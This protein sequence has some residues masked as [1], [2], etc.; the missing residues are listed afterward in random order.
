MSKVLRVSIARSGEVI[1]QRISV[2]DGFFSRLIG[3]LG[4]SSLA[5]DEGLLITRCNQVHM[6]GMRFPIDIIFLSADERVLDCIPELKPWCFSRK[7]SGAAK[8]LE[9]PAGKLKSHNLILGDR[10]QFD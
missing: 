8:I 1:G 7:V 10:L 5:P 3:L 9:L 2:A 4:R 6:F